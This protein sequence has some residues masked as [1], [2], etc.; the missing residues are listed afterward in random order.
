MNVSIGSSRDMDGWVEGQ[1]KNL[2]GK[3]TLDFKTI[4]AEDMQCDMIY[5]VVE[6]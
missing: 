1:G 6:I 4:E 3:T 2:C 5:N